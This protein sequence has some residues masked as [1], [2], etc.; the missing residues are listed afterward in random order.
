MKSMVRLHVVLALGASI[1]FV[2]AMACY[3]SSPPDDDADVQLDVAPD[4]RDSEGADTD[5]TESDGG[6][7]PAGMA[8]VL[9]GPFFMGCN[10]HEP[11]AADYCPGLPFPTLVTLSAY[12]IDRTEVT[13]AAYSACVTGAIC[14]PPSDFSAVGRDS[15]YDNPDYADYPV[16]YVSWL[17]AD[18]YC[19]WRRGRLPTTAEWEKAARGG[20]EVVAPDT[21]GPEDQRVYPWGNDEP[22][23]DQAEFDG[24]DPTYTARPG[25]THRAGSLP[26]GASPYGV[27]DLADNVEEW[28]YDWFGAEGYYEWWA[29][30]CAAGCIDPWGPDGP[31]GDPATKVICGSTSWR[32]PNQMITSFVNH[33]GGIETRDRRQGFRCVAPPSE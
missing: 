11:A 18:K 26:A 4:G 10:G 30:N 29:T 21:C 8:L 20:C 9:A 16:I 7:C 12:C 17:D 2:V 31:I 14:D 1:A 23:C 19:G 27:L 6:A 13:N 3:T 22:R 32:Y 5:V 33:G 24:C 25:L 28:T 15:Y